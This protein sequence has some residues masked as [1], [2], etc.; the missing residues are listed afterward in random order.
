MSYIVKSIVYVPES[1]IIQALVS[2]AYKGINQFAVM[3]YLTSDHSGLTTDIK[4]LI[5]TAT[6][7]TLVL[8]AISEKQYLIDNPDL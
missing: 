1:D 5:V 7:D 8:N 4:A 2:F 6:F 3:S